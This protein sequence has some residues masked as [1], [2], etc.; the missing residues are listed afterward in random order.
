MSY[1]PYNNYSDVEKKDIIKKLYLVQKQSFQDIATTL[2]TYP[3]KIRR[4]AIRLG[5]TIRDK[6][7][8]QANALATGKHKHPTKGV[9]RPESTKQKI[10]FSVMSSW[11]SLSKTEKNKRKEQ[12][13]KLWEQLDDEEKQHR[14]NLAHQAVRESS[15]IGSK[16][17]KFL[18][19]RLIQDGY[20]VDFHKEQILSNTKLQIDLF[21]P[22]MNIAIEV[23]G[24]SHFL[25]V[26]GEETLKKNITYDNKKNGLIIGKGLKLIRIKQL[27]DFSVARSQKLYVDL[28]QGIQKLS[29]SKD[30]TLEIED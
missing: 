15:K 7:Q 18:L 1:K 27:H 19:Q 22:T 6:S 30:K 17:E 4:D 14:L 8:A 25:P 20:K 3:N 5:I 21:L 9:A 13:R 28:I 29:Q 2:N 12:S 10:G 16:L 23:D 11:D 26:W 24:P